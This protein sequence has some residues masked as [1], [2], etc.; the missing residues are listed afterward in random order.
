MDNRWDKKC[1]R[2]IVEGVEISFGIAIRA[3]MKPDV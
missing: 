2:K 1:T 3:E